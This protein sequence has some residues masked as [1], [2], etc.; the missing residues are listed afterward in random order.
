MKV[1]HFKRIIWFCDI[2]S[3]QEK[4][5]SLCSPEAKEMILFFSGDICCAPWKAAARNTFRGP[6]STEYAFWKPSSIAI[7]VRFANFLSASYLF[8]RDTCVDE[9]RQTHQSNYNSVK[10]LTT[11]S[12]NEWCMNNLFSYFLARYILINENRNHMH[13]AA[14]KHQDPGT[15]HSAGLIMTISY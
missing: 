7:I 9:P 15:S 14:I 6:K 12:T 4:R 8:S 5:G 2:H 10:L 13:Y 1:T 3:S 11:N